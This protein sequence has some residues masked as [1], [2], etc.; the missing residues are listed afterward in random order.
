MVDRRSHRAASFIDDAQHDAPAV[1]P[2]L[3]A[4]RLQEE[5]A[6]ARQPLVVHRA[7]G[8]ALP[9]ASSG[10]RMLNDRIVMCDPDGR[11]YRI[12]EG[13]GYSAAASGDIRLRLVRPT[14]LAQT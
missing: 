5:E 1:A 14:A 7:D 4:V 10:K 8:P 3:G 2:R 11:V 12:V 13:R 6:P 9:V